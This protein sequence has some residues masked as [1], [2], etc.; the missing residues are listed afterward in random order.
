MTRAFPLIALLGATLLACG[1]YGRFP[2]IAKADQKVW[3]ESD[4]N[5]AGKQRIYDEKKFVSWRAPRG[6]RWVNLG[7]CSN[8]TRDDGRIARVCTWKVV[9]GE[10]EK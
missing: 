2:K 8:R 10:P 5:V 1:V 3:G 4:E 6:H 9:W 7:G